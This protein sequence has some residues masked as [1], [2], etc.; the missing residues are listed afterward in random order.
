M[1]LQPDLDE[2][3]WTP[4]ITYGEATMTIPPVEGIYMARRRLGG[5]TVY[6][7]RAGTRAKYNGLQGRFRVYKGGN[8]TGLTENALTQ[9]LRDSAWIRSAADEATRGAYLSGADLV[10]R[11]VDFA[12]LEISWTLCPGMDN[13]T[14]ASLERAVRA[15][16]PD[17]TGLW[18]K[19]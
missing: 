1:T 19:H 6:V 15:G 4:W 2:L 10:R 18:S 17:Q 14:L 9:A 12:D 11:A 5:M 8:M 13:K 7:G 16:V 3:E